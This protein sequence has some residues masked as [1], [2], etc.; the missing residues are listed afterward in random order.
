MARTARNEKLDTRSARAN[1]A[2]RREPY[3]TVISKGSALGYRKGSRGGT[4]VARYRD[5]D[6]KQHYEAIG[7]ADDCRDPNGVDVLSFAHAQAKARE[8]FDAKARGLPNEDEGGEDR[9]SEGPH[10]VEDAMRAYLTWYQRHNKPSGYY[11]AVTTNRTHINPALG[12]V[13]LAKLTTEKIRRWHEGLADAPAM[14]RLKAGQERRYREQIGE[15]DESRKRKATA[16]R[17]LTTLKAALNHAYGKGWVASDDAWRRVKPFRAVDTAR[18]RYLTDDQCKR[19][20]NACDPDFRP[21]VQAALFTGMRYGELTG[22]RGAD[23]NPDSGTVHVRQ[24]KSGKDRHVVLTDEGREFFARQAVGKDGE[25]ILFTK[26]D[27]KPWGRSHQTR[28]VKEACEGATIVP[29]ASFHTLR[30]T[31][32]SRLVMR[33]APLVVVAT[34][35]GHSD[36]R[37]VEKHYGHLAPSYVAETIRTAF[38]ELGIADQGNVVSLNG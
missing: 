2:K 5:D 14:L 26:S 18:M 24:S 28:P 16:N 17:V 21:L 27:G 35:L 15:P 7:P 12:K 11:F 6:G 13:Q 23:F 19:L 8:W 37:M 1:L 34:Q 25:A 29:P 30:H 3:W 31:Y 4:W 33:N 36:T 20:V 22:L 38:G 32:A 9:R 10:T